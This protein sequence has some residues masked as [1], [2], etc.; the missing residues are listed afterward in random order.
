MNRVVYY[1]CS[2]M[3][4]AKKME[5]NIK[6]ARN[7]SGETQKQMAEKLGVALPTYRDYEHGKIVM[8]VD[9]A[10]KFASIVKIP[11]DDI[12]FT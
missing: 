7:Y 4:G 9:T 6:Q 1:T 3:K 11:I 5:F 10:K 8:R 12:S 2:Q